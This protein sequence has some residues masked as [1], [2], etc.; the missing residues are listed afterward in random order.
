MTIASCFNPYALLLIFYPNYKTTF[1]QDDYSRTAPDSRHLLHHIW[2]LLFWIP[3]K[4]H[5]WIHLRRSSHRL[6][7][8]LQLALAI[9]WDSV[10]GVHSLSL[11]NYRDEI[12]W[13]CVFSFFFKITSFSYDLFSFHS[14]IFW[15]II[16]IELGCCRY[17]V[18]F[19]WNVSND[20]TFVVALWTPAHVSLFGYKTTCDRSLVLK[21]F[22]NNWK[23]QFWSMNRTASVYKSG[24]EDCCSRSWKESDGWSARRSQGSPSM[25][26]LIPFLSQS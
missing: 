12:H 6:P 8:F 19:D 14:Y 2:R 15:K 20:V 10:S 13:L 21:G 22:T 26:L 3:W 5:N 24:K 11:K 23:F 17:L 25:F 18:I 1:F 16:N 7:S 9:P 4:C